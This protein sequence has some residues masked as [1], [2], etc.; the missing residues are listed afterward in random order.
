MLKRLSILVVVAA[1]LLALLVY[2]QQRQATSKVSGFIEADEIRLGSRVGGRVAE[3][4]VQ[5]GAAV[6]VGELLV[7]LEAFD[8][9][10]R[11]SEAEANLAARR[12]EWDRLRHGLRAEE[13]EQAAHRVE[14]LQAN[15]ELLKKGPRE[16]EIQAAQARR[17][18]AEAQWERARHSHERLVALLPAGGVAREEVDRATEELKVAEQMRVVREQELR[19]LEKGSREEEIAA[20]AAQ[21]REAQAALALAQKGFREE[22]IREAQAA[23][24]SAQA[25]L[26]AVREMQRELRIVAPVDGVVEAVELQKGDL[27]AA[28]APVLSLMDTTSLWVRAYVPEDELRLQIGQPLPVTVDSYPGRRFR[29]EVTFISRQAEFTPRNVQTPEE[30]SQQVFR[31]KVTL[32]EG[33]DVLRPGMNADVWLDAS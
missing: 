13:I 8:L 11:V 15:L 33:L 10:E 22:E 27:V 20:A 3:V 9:D 7:L 28:N 1:A 18:L 6:T 23:V 4:H 17:D 24:A 5:E 29:G 32:R 25:A 21:L 26:E 14:R 19:L 2:S 12:A 30:R 16:E 31:I